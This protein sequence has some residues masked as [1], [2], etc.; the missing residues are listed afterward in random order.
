MKQVQALRR[1]KEQLENSSDK[2]P[3]LDFLLEYLEHEIRYHEQLQQTTPKP[4][5]QQAE[6]S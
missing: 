2:G 3:A 1:L 5:G 4:P 6:N